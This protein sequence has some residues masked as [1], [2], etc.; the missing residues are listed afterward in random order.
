MNERSQVADPDEK[1]SNSSN[2]PAAG[3]DPEAGRRRV[4]AIAIALFVVSAIISMAA[5][6]W[7][8]YIDLQVYRDGARVWL[9]GGD[10]YGPLPKVGG[11][12]LP[13][14]YP[15]LAALVFTPL[16]LLPLLP[17]EWL[18]LA[19]AIGSLALTVWLV[20]RRLRPRLDRRTGLALVIGAVAL[21]GLSEPI[22]Q[23]Y[24]FGQINLFLMTAIALDTLVRKPFWPRG[25]LI[26]IAVA[27]KLTPGGFLLYFLIRRDWRAAR[28]VALSA[29]G[30]IAAGFALFPRE[31]TRY[32]FHILPDTGRIGPPYYAGNQSL[33]GFA[34]RLGLDTSNATILWLVTS[35]IAV[36][37]AAILMK[38]LFD[39]AAF[40]RRHESPDT[41][42]PASNAATIAALT[43]NAAAVLLISPVSW[44]HHW[45]WV[46]PAAL[47]AADAVERGGRSRRYLLATAAIVVMFMVGPQWLLP[48]GGDRERGWAV[49]E[50]LVGSSYVLVTFAVLVIAVVAYRPI[51]RAVG[52]AGARKA[53][54]AAE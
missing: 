54:N 50:E 18:V 14:T 17:A 15:P 22:R 12:E 7:R 41:P 20:L 49:W 5:G 26:G 2:E 42:A 9:D 43:V 46:A 44:S 21:L 39:D 23:T 38:R 37:L 27:I 11:L 45:V 30:A 29:L 13:F 40:A 31:S 48:H 19:L 47:V 52:S 35:L 28:N 34:F 36:A 32:W 24:N 8:G 10:L 3:S 4:V 1:P 33:K 25:M 6:L 16:A 53:A 51:Y